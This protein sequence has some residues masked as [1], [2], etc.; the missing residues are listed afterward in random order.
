SLKKQTSQYL[1]TPVLF[2]YLFSPVTY[3]KLNYKLHANKDST[4]VTKV[5]KMEKFALLI[6]SENLKQLFQLQINYPL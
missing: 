4:R 2:S 5:T 1:T 3:S 6:A